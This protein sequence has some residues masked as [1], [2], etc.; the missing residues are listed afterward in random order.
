MSK[1]LK[2]A[3]TSILV[4][5][6][7]IVVYACITNA[8]KYNNLNDYTGTYLILNS[9]YYISIDAE[10][11]EAYLYNQDEGIYSDLEYNFVEG[12]G[13][14]LKNLDAGINGYLSYESGKDFVFN[15]DANSSWQVE[16]CGDAAM[17]K[18][19]KS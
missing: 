17:S 2:L 12:K 6:V 16:K 19:S 18:T 11:E 7:A 13:V 3:I 10:A 14:H 5:T 9:P 8:T 4:I 1:S 15:D